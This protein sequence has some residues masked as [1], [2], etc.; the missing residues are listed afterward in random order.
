MTWTLTSFFELLTYFVQ[1]LF[2]I[3][4][5]LVGVRPKGPKQEIDK[6]ESE[7]RWFGEAMDPRVD[8]SLGGRD[9]T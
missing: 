8:P 4:R 6:F 7:W 3:M 9:P 2:S 5:D 1:I